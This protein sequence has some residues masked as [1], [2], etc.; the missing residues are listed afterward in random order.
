MNGCLSGPK[1]T[2][3][4]KRQKNTL[5]FKSLSVWLYLRYCQMQLAG[6]NANSDLWIKKGKK[7]QDHK[8]KNVH[9]NTCLGT[10]TA[11]T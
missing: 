4:R 7:A 2:E 1:H 10:N 9:I 11:E 8:Q 3:H 5:F 6:G